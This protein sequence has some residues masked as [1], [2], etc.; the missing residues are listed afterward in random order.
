MQDVLKILASTRSRPPWQKALAYNVKEND[1][2]DNKQGD[3][4]LFGIQLSKAAETAALEQMQLQILQQLDFRDRLDRHNRIPIAHKGTFQWIYASQNQLVN[5]NVKSFAEWLEGRD[6]LYWITGKPGSGKST[7]M[8]FIVSD[9]R[10]RTHLRVWSRGMELITA[11]FY[12]WNSGSDVQMSLLGLLRTL[13]CDTLYACPSLIPD[14][15][16]SR[17]AQTSL[18]G[19]AVQPW[20]E[21]ELLSAFSLTVARLAERCK[22]CLFIDGL[23]EFS[24]RHEQL[25]Q[26]VNHAL[27]LKN[28]KICL[29]SRPWPIFDDAYG[30]RANLMLQNLTFDDIKRYATANLCSS[31]GFEA[32]RRS[33]PS[34]ASQLVERIAEKAEGV[35][36]WVSLVVDSLLKGMTNRDRILDLERRLEE[37]PGDL[38]ELYQ[39]ILNSIESFYLGHA[40]QLFQLVREGKGDFTALTLS[41]ADGGETDALQAAIDPMSTE[42]KDER[43]EQMKFR[44]SSRC[45]GF[46]E[47]PTFIATECTTPNTNSPLEHE[48]A[49]ANPELMGTRSSVPSRPRLQFN[50][51]R[52]ANHPGFSRLTWSDR[53][54]FRPRA[55]LSSAREPLSFSSPTPFITREGERSIP[56][57]TT[58][59]E[60]FNMWEASEALN[61]NR[62]PFGHSEQLPPL[63][64]ELLPQNL[65]NAGP[66]S[67]REMEIEVSSEG[68]GT[69]QIGDQANR[70]TSTPPSQDEAER[71]HGQVRSEPFNVTNDNFSSFPDRKVAYLHRTARDFLEK[72]EVWYQIMSHSP[73]DFVLYKAILGSLIYELKSLPRDAR[74]AIAVSDCIHRTFQ[75]SAYLEARGVPSTK[76]SI[77]LEEVIRVAIEQCQK[78]WIESVR[79][80]KTVM[81]IRKRGERGFYAAAAEYPLHSIVQQKLLNGMQILPEQEHRSL[82][83]CA[84]ADYAAYASLC[85]FSFGTS[86]PL[87]DIRFIRR[88]LE[89][90]EDPNQLYRGRTPWGCV[91]QE[92]CKVSAD[93]SID[94]RLKSDLLSVWAEIVELFI[95]HKANPYENRNAPNGNAI[96][97]AFGRAM[98][99]KS[100]QLELK[101]DKSKRRISRLGNFFLG[102]HSFK[103]TVD[104]MPLY[105]LRQLQKAQMPGLTHAEYYQQK[106][107]E[108]SEPEPENALKPFIH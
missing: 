68:I 46:L 69:L 65:R 24:G 70:R 15:F 22:I 23:D 76:W 92:A 13:L 107:D 9:E 12:F 72:P 5:K 84:I 8:K 57:P 19:E 64:Y 104:T 40:S 49:N 81:E 4:R 37:I 56:Y 89:S 83:D 26:V 97:A 66:I 59:N 82:L 93:D 30:R 96:R 105:R 51:S 87:P 55:R 77:E 53:E 62:R 35:Y 74:G 10:T 39:K 78:V 71:S 45:K 38:E 100:R 1:L 27:S 32:L 28:V 20:T 58:T 16:P 108:K 44:L 106:P 101:L 88:L 34:Y 86:H 14:V 52:E 60:P 36:L 75:Y 94:T 54:R 18:V 31:R 25:L 73:A 50:Y 7:L 6:S 63:R 3:V 67:P 2:R 47:I 85:D 99:D 33:E 29:A 102:G 103:N 17:W 48:P 11:S 98:P 43:Y 61:A 41:F 42:E 91:L 80:D 90:G 79:P 95:T 21:E